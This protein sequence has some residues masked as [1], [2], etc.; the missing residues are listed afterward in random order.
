MPF[1]TDGAISLPCQRRTGGLQPGIIDACIRLRPKC[2]NFF[3]AYLWGS[4][5]GKE[6]AYDGRVTSPDRIPRTLRRCQ[7]GAMRPDEIMRAA[8]VPAGHHPALWA[9]VAPLRDAMR[10]RDCGQDRLATLVGRDRS[11]V[12]RWLSGRMLPRLQPLLEIAAHLQV[13]AGM[14]R[15]RWEAATAAMQEP[16]V[17]REARLAG[18]APPARLTTHADLRRA[19]LRLLRTRGMSIRDLERATPALRHS[20]VT[21]SLNGDRL[22]S[23]ARVEAIVKACGVHGMAVLAWLRVWERVCGPEWRRREAS[24]VTR[25]KAHR[26]GHWWRHR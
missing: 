14:I 17:R 1:G 15:Q 16:D 20:T 26:P 10:E 25:A 3:P 24:R 8:A 23:A 6:P 7:T 21:A 9:L 18:G 22:L 4:D 13:D 11:T 2:T 5:L 12:S 19:L